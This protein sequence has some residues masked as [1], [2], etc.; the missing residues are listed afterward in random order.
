MQSPA[1]LKSDVINHTHEGDK[2]CR[3]YRNLL[4][5]HA[6]IVFHGVLARDERQAVVQADAVNTLTGA[7]QL[8]Q[9]IFAVRG[10][11]RLY[12]VG[13]AEVVK[14]RC[15]FWVAAQCYVRS[16]SLVHCTL[17]HVVGIPV[18][19]PGADSV[20]YSNSP[21]ASVYRL[22]HSSVGW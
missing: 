2:E 1:A 15:T 5:V 4:A 14:N 18:A 10:L 12:R 9:L 6:G 17:S 3:T 21:V 20:G 8:G 16:E 7:D 11:C 19:Y 22:K 13:P